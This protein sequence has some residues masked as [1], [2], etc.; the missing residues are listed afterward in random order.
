MTPSEID[1]V[2]VEALFASPLESSA[3]PT[4]AQIRA[5]VATSLLRHGVTGCAEI[6]AI[7]FGDHPELA[8][9]RMGWVRA[10]VG[11]AYPWSAR[12]RVDRDRLVGQARV[13][14]K[15]A[16]PLRHTQLRAS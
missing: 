6:V 9:R 15:K 16:H 4:L 12:R 5:A 10:A 1:S 2:R 8:V 7:E 11:A 13:R 3:A 14:R